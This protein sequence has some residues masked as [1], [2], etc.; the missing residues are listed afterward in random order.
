M[1]SPLGLKKGLGPPST[2]NPWGT[3]F[4]KYA[5]YVKCGSEIRYS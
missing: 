1:E 3:Y 4:Y 2:N 5:R